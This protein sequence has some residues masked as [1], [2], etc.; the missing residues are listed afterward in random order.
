M[1]NAIIIDDEAHARQTI[2]AILKSYYDDIN[3]LAEA[4]AFP[5][6]RFARREWI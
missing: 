4:A 3:I 2:R 1:I 5:R 6:H